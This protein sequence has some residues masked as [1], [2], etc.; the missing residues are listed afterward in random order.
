MPESILMRKIPILI[1][2]ILVA[3]ASLTSC[4][5]PVPDVTLVAPS[6]AD[7]TQEPEADTPTPEPP[8]TATLEPQAAVVNGQPIS[9]AEYEQQVARYEA[10]MV[11]AGQDLS[12]EEGKQ[13]L[14]Q[15]RQWVLDLMIEQTLIE[16]S[17]AEQG[18]AISD[19]TL[20]SN[21]CRVAE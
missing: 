13:A 4:A 8:P 11:A 17:A 9:M 14:A 18:I 2:L 6:T 15:G 21:N 10:S 3:L 19:E 7:A 1:L 20:D 5:D 16:Q 12:T